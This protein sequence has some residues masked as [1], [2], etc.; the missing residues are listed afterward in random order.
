MIANVLRGA[1]PELFL[2]DKNNFP[3]TSIGLIGGSKQKPRQLGGGFALQEDNVAVEFNIPPA[4]NKEQFISS[5]SFVLS[6][7]EQ[8]LGKKDLFLDISPVAMFTTEQLNHP[9]AQELGCEP[10]FNAWTQEV[11]P[12]PIAPPAL[13]SAGGHLHIGYDDPDIVTNLRIVKVHDLFCGVA[14]LIHDGDTRRRELYG[15]A[16]A[17]RHKDY[18]VEYRSM[19]NYWIK[20]PELMG[21]I[22]TQSEKA[23][24]F[25]NGNN[26]IESEDAQKIQD[27]INN[28]DAN[29]LAELNEKFAIL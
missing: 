2:R 11:N 3:V 5:L 27:C 10:D 1:D 12:R 20:S 9:Q 18:G 15:K 23:I 25:L 26:R 6:H 29:L 19:S 7:L 4:N 22:Y 8:E 24:S 16:G 17:F 21:W 28:S 14:S 13:R